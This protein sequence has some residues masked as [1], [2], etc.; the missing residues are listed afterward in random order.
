[1]AYNQ[2]QGLGIDIAWVQQAQSL[3]NFS[4]AG[5]VFCIIGGSYNV[6]KSFNLTLCTLVMKEEEGTGV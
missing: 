5:K 2:S 1:M 4:K 6:C 3:L